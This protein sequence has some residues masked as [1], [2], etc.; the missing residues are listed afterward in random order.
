MGFPLYAVTPVLGHSKT[1][2]P[3]NSVFFRVLQL[4]DLSLSQI[5]FFCWKPNFFFFHF[6]IL[7]TWRKK[8]CP[9]LGWLEVSQ[10][11][12][13]WGLGSGDMKGE[14]HELTLGGVWIGI[15]MELWLNCLS[16]AFSLSLGSCDCIL[17]THWFWSWG[18]FLIPSSSFS[19][20]KGRADLRV[21]QQHS[22]H[23]KFPATI[24]FSLCWVV[25]SLSVY[26]RYYAFLLLVMLWLSV[27]FKCKVT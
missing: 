23:L 22:T 18:I 27:C 10:W 13:N 20:D 17:S 19:F 12:W 5:I 1:V 16:I 26:G 3:Q 9:L 24:W 15:G 25:E 14:W 21:Q 7:S 11:Q 8:W 4:Q 6:C 2:H